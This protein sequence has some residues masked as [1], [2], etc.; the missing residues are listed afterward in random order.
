MIWAPHLISTFLYLAS[1]PIHQIVATKILTF[2][3]SREFSD[4]SITSDHLDTLERTQKWVLKYLGHRTDSVHQVIGLSKDLWQTR[5]SLVSLKYRKHI[6]SLVFIYKLIY[7]NYECSWVL[8]ILSF[9]VPR[10]YSRSHQI[11]YM[12]ASECA[13]M[14]KLLLQN[15]RLCKDFNPDNIFRSNRIAHLT[16]KSTGNPLPNFQRKQITCYQM[17]I[18]FFQEKIKLQQDE[19]RWICRSSRSEVTHLKPCLKSYDKFMKLVKKT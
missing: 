2:L 1:F 3:N 7:F 6:S 9:H 11:F 10:I 13:Q 15:E 5:F 17:Q 12:N 19:M 18:S 8:I 4:L 16:M 14:W